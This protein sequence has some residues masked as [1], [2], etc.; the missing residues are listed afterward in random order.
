MFST[1]PASCLLWYLFSKQVWD[2]GGFFF[3][4]ETKDE[5]DWSGKIQQAFFFSPNDILL[6]VDIT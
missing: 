3:F 6:P 2:G 5:K 4:S 1:I